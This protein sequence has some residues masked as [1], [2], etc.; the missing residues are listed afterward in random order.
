M[1]QNNTHATSIHWIWA[2]SLSLSL[3]HARTH[4]RAYSYEN[5]NVSVFPMNRNRKSYWYQIHGP[6]WNWAVKW[7][8]NFELI[9]IWTIPLKDPLDFLLKT[10]IISWLST[11]TIHPSKHLETFS[12]TALSNAALVGTNQVQ[13]HDD[14]SH[15]P[16]VASRRY[17]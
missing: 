1:D 17:L 3:S 16:L 6:E 5:R 15:V 14:C 9:F 8:N 4:T 10:L 7:L 2:L 13:S 11:F 12:S